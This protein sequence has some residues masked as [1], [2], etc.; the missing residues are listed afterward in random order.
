M[1]RTAADSRTCENPVITL[2]LF[3][4]LSRSV[5]S[6]TPRSGRVSSGAEAPGPE[7]GKYLHTS[8]AHSQGETA[9][10]LAAGP[11]G[12]RDE[13]ARGRDQTGS[14]DVDCGAGRSNMLPPLPQWQRVPFSPGTRL[15]P[16]EIVA[17]LGSGGM[18]VVYRA[19]DLRLD[20]IVAI[21]VVG[22]SPDA[23]QRRQ[24][25]QREMRAIATLNHPHICSLYDVGLQEDVEFFVM[26]YLEGETLA[27]RLL[28]GP[29]PMADTLRH[30]AAL[31]DA[32]AL[33][34]RHG[35]VHRDIKP[36][37]IMLTASGVKLLDFGLAKVSRQGGCGGSRR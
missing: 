25:F 23:A 15:G 4:P 21:K 19:H 37:N 11:L 2:G 10:P 33:A 13:I 36:G 5:G 29:L 35:I 1:A 34:H 26:E 20:R 17:P 24:R 14:I 27:N 28:K 8:W 18:G 9:A 7:M 32:V 22:P 31:A 12:P 6:S 16:Y 30:A 3:Q